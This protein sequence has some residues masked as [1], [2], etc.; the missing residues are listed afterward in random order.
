MKAIYNIYFHS[1]AKI[2]GPRTWSASRLPFI[3]A[4]LKGTI[5]QDLQ[6]L[7]QKYGPVLRIAPDEVTFAQPE[8]WNDILQPQ[9]GKQFLKDPTWWSAQ[10]GMSLTILSAIQPEPHARIRKL[11]APALSL[12]ALKDQ[13][14][15]VNRY[16]NLL[17][18]RLQEYASKAPSGEAATIDIGPWFNFTTF[19][20]IGDLAYGESFECLE[21][22][23][24][25]EWIK[26]VFDSVKGATWVASTRF[27]PSVEY[28]L[29]KL[30]SPYLRRMQVAHFGYIA[31]KV[32][33]RLN[34]ETQ[35][36]DFMSHVIQG[37][38]EKALP[39][40]Q[41]NSTFVVL[42]N[43]GSETTAT[44]L[45]G[46]MHYLINHPDKLII[47]VDEIRERFQTADEI[48]LDALQQLPF[49]NAVLKEGLRL[50]PP[51]PW[52]LPRRVPA[53]G[54]L[55]CGTW[56][57]AGVGAW[58]CI[59]PPNLLRNVPPLNLCVII[60][61]GYQF[62]HTPCIAIQTSFMPLHP[63]FPNGGCQTP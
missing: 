8:A 54:S 24:F 6:K 63:L 29:L 61:Y 20:I 60:R 21:N 30:V 44:A 46:T 1:L 16:A 52:I 17:V 55:V 18:E 36:P 57:P 2:P 5:I 50:C 40:D 56:L 19:D 43:A 13:E 48:S 12:R 62:K 26:R 34:W 42:T 53:G 35:R 28:V 47:V 14:P 33:R 32:Y 39:I 7:H 22:S 25:H 51:I 27:Y 49:L 41:I 38:V 31:Q 3:R 59:L 10:P 9:P 11:F 15:I 23:R 45:S 37:G 4:L 58:T